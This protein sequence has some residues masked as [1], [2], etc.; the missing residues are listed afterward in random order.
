MIGEEFADGAE[1]LADF[2]VGDVFWVIGECFLDEGELI[3]GLLDRV[4]FLFAGEG[5]GFL[6]G[7][8]G[9][10]LDAVEGGE[11]FEKVGV[12]DGRAVGLGNGDEGAAFF[13]GATNFIVD[14]ADGAD[15]A[16][17]SHVAGGCEVGVDFLSGDDG[18]G[19]EGADDGGGGAILGA[20]FV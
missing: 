14:A 4:G 2:G 5:L 11:T 20:V 9:E 8:D 19:E 18:V 16:S 1:F 15:F 10:D 6:E 7:F 12:I 3:D 13:C 17:C